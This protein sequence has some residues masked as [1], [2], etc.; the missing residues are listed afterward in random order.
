MCLAGAG[1]LVVFFFLLGTHVS[2]ASTKPAY[3][4]A[5]TGLGGLQVRS[6]GGDG[7]S[8]GVGLGTLSFVLFYSGGKEEKS[9]LSRKYDVVTHKSQTAVKSIKAPHK[10][11]SAE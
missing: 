9:S 3:G 1:I 11:N 6:T 10:G 7:R 5:F 8:Q 4:R 2:R